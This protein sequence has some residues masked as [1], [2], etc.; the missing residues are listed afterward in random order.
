MLAQLLG[1]NL[2]V[3]RR[4]LTNP[5]QSTNIIPSELETRLNARVMPDFFDVT[6]DPTQ[7]TLGG[8]RS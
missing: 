4:P 1:D 8:S 3:T 6:D 5:G 7:R 2:R